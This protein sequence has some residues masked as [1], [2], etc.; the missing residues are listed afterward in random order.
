MSYVSI[1]QEPK[2][3]FQN[4]LKEGP[5]VVISL[6]ERSRHQRTDTSKTDS[7]ATLSRRPMSLN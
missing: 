6:K 4:T 1:I 2:I 3:K 5:T 7:W